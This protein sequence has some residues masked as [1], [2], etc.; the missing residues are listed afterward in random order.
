MTVFKPQTKNDLKQAINL[1]CDNETEARQKY[2]DSN[3]WDVSLIT[4]MS[5]LFQYKKFTGNISNWDV[6]NVTNMKSMFTGCKFNGDISNWVVSKVRDMSC[7]FHSSNFNGDIS[8]WDVS[9]VRDMFLMFYNSSFNDNINKWNISNVWCGKNDIEEYIHKYNEILN[10]TINLENV[11]IY[12]K[13]NIEYIVIKKT[14]NNVVI[15]E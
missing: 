5:Y 6:S 10:R 7:M 13:N 2:G 8:N 15:I 9:N 11:K 1:W 12:N 14:A 4:D 3:T